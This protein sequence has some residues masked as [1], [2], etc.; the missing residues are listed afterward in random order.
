MNYVIKFEVL[1]GVLRNALVQ[2]WGW[3]CIHG[4]IFGTGQ[5]KFTERMSEFAD[6]FK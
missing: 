3:F 2:S 5:E 6:M 1:P 4:D